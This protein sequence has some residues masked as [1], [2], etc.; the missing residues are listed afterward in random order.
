MVCSGKH[1][2]RRKR[3]DSLGQPKGSINFGNKRLTVTS[4]GVEVDVSVGPYG[5]IVR[6]GGVQRPFN[7]T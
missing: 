5:E 6:P 7:S 2:D 4:G 1:K 3:T